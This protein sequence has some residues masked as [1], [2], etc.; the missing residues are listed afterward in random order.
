MGAAKCHWHG[1]QKLVMPLHRGGWHAWLL[2]DCESTWSYCMRMML[3]CSHLQNHNDSSVIF[4]SKLHKHYQ[5]QQK[6]RPEHK[7]NIFTITPIGTP[8]SC[9]SPLSEYG[10]LLLGLEFHASVEYGWSYSWTWNSI[11]NLC[12]QKIYEVAQTFFLWR[13]WGRCL[14]FL[15]QSHHIYSA[16]WILRF[17]ASSFMF[18]PEFDWSSCIW[19][20][21]L[22]PYEK[23]FSPSKCHKCQPQGVTAPWYSPLQGSGISK[24]G[25]RYMCS[26]VC[27]WKWVQ[28]L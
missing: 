14:A 13:I 17:P 26:G 2:V 9:L 22:M 8:L 19:S 12:Y 18:S 3:W 1:L 24:K 21:L 11:W 20:P 15:F 4:L 5:H 27:K 25:S 23:V 28:S 16:N 7:I 6:W 10:E